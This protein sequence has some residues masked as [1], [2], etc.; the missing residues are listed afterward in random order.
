MK[1]LQS[2][3]FRALVAIV[4]GALII[5]Y[6]EDT[7][8]WLT[9]AIGAAFFISGLI[10][11]AVYYSLRK[12][13][14]KESVAQGSKGTASPSFP[15][16]GIGSMVLGGILALMPTTFITGLMYV[17]AAVLILGAINQYVS[18]G[19]AMRF[20]KVGWFYWIAPTLILLISILMLVKP[21]EMFA[22]P[23]FII[24]WCMV[25]YGVAECLNSLMIHR[26]RKQ[27]ERLE[28]KKAMEAEVEEIKEESPKETEEDSQKEAEEEKQKEADALGIDSYA[29]GDIL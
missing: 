9:I 28:Q 1:V 6:R 8:Q 27:F 18:L 14:A 23:L 3:I 12:Q 7:V 19:K 15:F 16:V 24:G 22:A 2:S 17:L 26:A 13:G 21:M 29:S 25:V 10:S 20:C 4:V 5:K 11:C